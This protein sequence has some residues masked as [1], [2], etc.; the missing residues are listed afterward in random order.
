MKAALAARKTRGLQLGKPESLTIEARIAGAATSKARAV[1]DIRPVAAYAGA[2]RAQGL[3]LR[4]VAAQLDAHGF[5]TRQGGPWSDVQVKRLLDR[6]K[7]EV[8]DPAA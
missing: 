1:T 5:R 2:L 4:A 3:S 6:K 8:A 7:Q